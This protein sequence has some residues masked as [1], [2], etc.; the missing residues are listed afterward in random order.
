MIPWQGRLKFRMCSLGKIKY[1]VLVSMVCEAVM[2]YICK[3]KIYT[4]EGQNL[5]ET[6]LSLLD[7]NLVQNHHI[8]QAIS[9]IV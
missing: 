7:R 2:G 5:E 6:A 1:G 9:I 4:A 8:Y 3:I